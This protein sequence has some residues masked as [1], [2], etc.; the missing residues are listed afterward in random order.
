RLNRV[1]QKAYVEFLRLIGVKLYPPSAAT[2]TLSFSLSRPQNNSV[3]IPRGARVTIGRASGANEAP[4]FVT[5][6][7]V[8]IEPGQ[9][10]VETPACHWEL[11]E[12]ELLGIGN[13]APGQRFTVARPPIIA[14][15]GD[16]LDLIVGVEAL[17]QELNERVPALK[18]GDKTFRIWREV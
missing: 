2:V 12:G 17:P 18:H 5:T 3:E 4:I 9:Q 1:P 14:P 11:V 16:D 13:G 7:A 10:S 6:R 15:T 8:R